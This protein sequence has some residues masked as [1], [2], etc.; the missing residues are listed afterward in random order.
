MWSDKKQ[1]Y[2]IKSQK[3]KSKT[4]INNEEK[5]VIASGSVTL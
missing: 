5:R 1:C 2:E 3:N 4:Y